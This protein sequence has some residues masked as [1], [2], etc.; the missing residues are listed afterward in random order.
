LIELFGSVSA[1]PGTTG[2]YYYSEFFKYYDLRATYEPLKAN[3]L[4]EVECFLANNLYS[5]FNVSMPFKSQVIKYLDFADP[6]VGVYNS[7]NTVKSQQNK[8]YG[9]NTDIYGVIKIIDSISQRDFVVVLGNGAIGKMTAAVLKFRNIKHEVVSPSL[10]N[11]NKRH[12]KCDILINCTSLGTSIPESPV[13]KI[14]GAHSVYDLTFKGYELQKK[15]TF[16][17]YYSG[18][19]F[20]KEVF[21]NQ[22]LLHTDIAP[23]AEYFDYL[24]K[25]RY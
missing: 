4:R 22:F 18:I 2:K 25:I 11:W 14:N 5:G 23:D 21:L 7:C 19:Y 6:D 8:L 1:S 24:T 3:D 15:C 12:Q 13:D 10:G 20:Y 9:Y 16:I 17:N